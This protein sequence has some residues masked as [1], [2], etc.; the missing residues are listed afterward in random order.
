MPDEWKG[1]ILFPRGTAEPLEWPAA[2]KLDPWNPDL[3][4]P[5]MDAQALAWKTTIDTVRDQIVNT[6]TKRLEGDVLVKEVAE[7][8]RLVIVH[9]A[10]KGPESEL[11]LVNLFDTRPSGVQDGSGHGVHH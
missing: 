4:G 8:L 7:A 1:A 11:L 6:S 2:M 3:T 5:D 9:D 10:I